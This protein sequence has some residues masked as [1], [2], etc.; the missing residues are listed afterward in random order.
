MSRVWIVRNARKCYCGLSLLCM[1]F[2]WNS[3]F[4]PFLWYFSTMSGPAGAQS[5]EFANQHVTWHIKVIDRVCKMMQGGLAYHL[6]MFF[7]LNCS[8]PPLKRRIG[9][10][11]DED[12]NRTEALFPVNVTHLFWCRKRN[13]KL[14]QDRWTGEVYTGSIFELDPIVSCWFTF[15]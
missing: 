8:S 13:L 12:G 6:I 14:T 1:F 4:L 11:C 7:L 2:C 10:F 3:V 5:T 15:F 9:Q